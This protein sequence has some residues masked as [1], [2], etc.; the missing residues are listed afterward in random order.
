MR[1]IVSLFEFIV[2]FTIAPDEVAQVPSSC[3]DTGGIVLR[4]YFCPDFLYLII[5]MHMLEISV[6]T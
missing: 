1:L 6:D 3:R 5:Y 4:S 2:K